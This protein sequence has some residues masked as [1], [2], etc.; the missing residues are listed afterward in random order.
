MIRNLYLLGEGSGGHFALYM[1][2]NV[3]QYLSGGI[4]VSPYVSNQADIIDIDTMTNLLGKAPS[5]LE[6]KQLSL[7]NAVHKEM[8]P[9]YLCHWMD[10]SD[11][12]PRHSILLLEKMDRAG[13]F[14]HTHFFPKGNREKYQLIQADEASNQ[15]WFSEAISFL[16]RSTSN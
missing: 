5:K 2:E 8:P 4:L 7:E 11:T 10:D 12:A 14:S 15:D 3:P 1:L 6:L 16:N 13:I 9:I